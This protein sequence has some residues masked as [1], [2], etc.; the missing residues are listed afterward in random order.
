MVYFFV[1][2]FLSNFRKVYI[3][4]YDR[5]ALVSGLRGSWEGGKFW[6][7]GLTLD[8][9]HCLMGS[10]IPEQK[11]GQDFQLISI[12]SMMLISKYYAL[13]RLFGNTYFSNSSMCLLVSNS[14]TTLIWNKIVDSSMIWTNIYFTK[15]I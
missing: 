14:D 3:H 2:S 15:K 7:G 9:W 11:L 1:F 6:W 13:L 8:R 12:G 4:F 5:K 10:L